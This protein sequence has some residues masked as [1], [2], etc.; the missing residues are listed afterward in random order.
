MAYLKQIFVLFC[1]AWIYNTKC[2]TVSGITGFAGYFNG[3]NYIETSYQSC[4][5]HN[6]TI[7]T[8]K[9]CNLIPSSILDKFTLQLYIKP[10][11][12]SDINGTYA[13]VNISDSF[14]LSYKVIKGII[15]EFIIQI[16]SNSDNYTTSSLSLIN[17]TYSNIAVTF[18]YT[19]GIRIFKNGLINQ[20]FGKFS[21]NTMLNNATNDMIIG[22]YLIGFLDEIYI[23]N[24][25]L[26]GNDI[27]RISNTVFNGDITNLIL[28]Y[29]FNKGNGNTVYD[30]SS[31]DNHG[32]V[33]YSDF[34][35]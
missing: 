17:N 34:W 26:S 19:D 35:V 32:T 24:E 14:K 8:Y 12:S 29:S 16:N 33:L 30:Y 13:L 5:D 7:N 1:V 11:F 20:D 31:N 27:Y 2:D 4:N 3:S 25:I 9:K 21:T 6:Y 23:Y 18:H 15:S 28:Y 22:E 10:I